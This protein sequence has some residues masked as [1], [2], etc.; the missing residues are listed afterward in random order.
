MIA[1]TLIA[2][3]ALDLLLP[4]GHH[5]HSEQANVSVSITEDLVY[6]VNRDVVNFN[7]LEQIL[8]EKLKNEEEP[9][10]SLHAERSVPIEYVVK[11]MNIAKDNKYR[12]I[13]ATQSY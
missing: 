6:A 3:N 7:N 1:S 13:L 10:I 9:T 4:E 8:R 2:P 5:Q 12:V 11:V